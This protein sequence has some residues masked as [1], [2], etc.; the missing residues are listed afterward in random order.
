MMSWLSLKV[1]EF[2]FLF[3]LDETIILSPRHKKMTS[4]TPPQAPLAPP[5]SSSSSTQ[6]NDALKTPEYNGKLFY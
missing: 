3:F 1:K 6:L 2:I 5:L 4:T